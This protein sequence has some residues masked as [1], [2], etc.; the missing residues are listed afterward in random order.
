MYWVLWM[1]YCNLDGSTIVYWIHWMGAVYRSYQ[2]T[3][4][5]LKMQQPNA[6]HGSLLN[7]FNAQRPM[8][9]AR[10]DCPIVRAIT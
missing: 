4:R 10:N 2:N 7:F 5:P 8:I 1:H 9:A 6:G 3:I